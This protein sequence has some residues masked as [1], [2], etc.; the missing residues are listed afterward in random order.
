VSYREE[1]GSFESVDDLT[2]VRGI[3]PKTL[4]RARPMLTVTPDAK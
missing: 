4:E 1:H 2:R 3:G